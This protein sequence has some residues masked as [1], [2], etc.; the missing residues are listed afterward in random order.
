MKNELNKLRDNNSIGF[1]PTM[2]YLHEGHLSLIQRA[3]NENDIVVLSIYVNPTQF[4][5]NE[6]FDKY[7]KDLEND[8]Q[9]AKKE[10]VDFVFVPNSKE[11]YPNGFS[12][13]IFE[14]ELSK[15]LCGKSRPN[16]FKGV[17]TVVG[18]LF[19]II[20]P[21]RAYFGQKDYQQYLILDK[22]VRDLNMDIEIIKCPIIREIDGLAMSSRNVYLS[23]NE[24]KKA[25]SISKSLI[26]AKEK[27]LNGEREKSTIIKFIKKYIISQGECEIDYI[28]IL[29]ADNLDNTEYIENNILITV[30]VKYGST[31]LIDNV[32]LEVV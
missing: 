31:R 24:R 2:G 28:E 12:T 5:E 30:A 25:L 10:N 22:M 23:S 9:L 8:L 7:P 14:T 21:N 4:G 20:K 13:Y 19:N 6:D 26:S 1:V 29:N 17:T 15:K 16:H 3:G 18:K 11:M 32:V 27:I